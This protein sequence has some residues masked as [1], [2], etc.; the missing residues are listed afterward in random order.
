MQMKRRPLVLPPPTTTTTTTNGEDQGLR[1]GEE[2]SSDSN[3]PKDNGTPDKRTTKTTNAETTRIRIT[4]T[5]AAA[6][7]VPTPSSQPPQLSLPNLNHTPSPLTR[8][9]ISSLLRAHLST[10]LAPSDALHACGASVTALLPSQPRA[11]LRVAHAK[12]HAFPFKD[13][14]ACWLRAW[15][16]ACLWECVRDEEEEEEEEWLNAVIRVLDMGLILAGGV[17]REDV[18]AWVFAALEVLLDADD[19]EREHGD[20]RP[21]K[22]RKVDRTW[23]CPPAFPPSTRPPPALRNPIPRVDARQFGFDAFQAHLDEGKHTNADTPTP[24]ILTNAL[25]HWPATSSPTRLWSNPRYLLRRTLGGRR[26][27]PV[28]I[29]RSYTDE[30][31]GQRIMSVREF[32]RRY[33]FCDDDDEEE[34]DEGGEKKQKGYLAQH[35]LLS[36][37]PRLR[38]D[39]AAPDYCYTVPPN[40][41]TP[42]PSSHPPN[43]SSPSHPDFPLLHAWLGPARTIS[44]LHTDPYHNLLA[45]VVGAKYVRLYAPSAAVKTRGVGADGVD[46]GNTGVVDVHEAMSV[47]RSERSERREPGETSE[48]SEKEQ[49]EG[50]QD[51]DAKREAFEAQHPG[52]LSL[53]CCDCVL[54]AGEVLYV[55]RGWWHYVESLAASFSV[56]FWWDRIDEVSG[57]DGE[58]EGDG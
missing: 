41:Q 24:L 19:A 37:I 30:G 56:S 45:Q 29:G 55:P 26:L 21:R 25:S 50:S 27:V 46:L 53:P 47:E 7:P 11:V 3:G 34:K 14:P 18:Y 39:I 8:S 57:G 49:S 54:G 22:R 31:W 40:T 43:P 15:S 48:R 10:T 17:G 51:G 58:Y 9:T 28:E 4:R 12:L 44:P 5:T 1:D 23:T 6:L 20:G 35:D 38:A 52:F 42:P 16:E 2:K 13:V 36:Q 32:V 33:V